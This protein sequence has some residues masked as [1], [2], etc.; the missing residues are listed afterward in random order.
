MAQGSRA[1][2]SV[3]LWENSFPTSLYISFCLLG[4]LIWLTTFW[5]LGLNH[6]HDGVHQ[7]FP[8]S[9]DHLEDVEGVGNHLLE[10]VVLDGHE[11]KLVGRLFEVGC[12]TFRLLD[13]PK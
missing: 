12:Y 5:A 3:E 4:G 2:T 7:D 11:R 8:G 6:W 10:E 9:V 1:G 13:V